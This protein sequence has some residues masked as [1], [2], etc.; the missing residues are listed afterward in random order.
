MSPRRFAAPRRFFRAAPLALAALAF[1]PA[2][3]QPGTTGQV[4]AVANPLRIR[5]DTGAAAPLGATV[6]TLRPVI[7]GTATV[8][9]LSGTYTV[10]GQA[11]ADVLVELSAGGGAAGGAAAGGPAVGHRVEVAHAARPSLIRI[12]SDPT[13]AAV[14]R[15]GYPLG[16]TPLLVEAAP[17]AHDFLVTAAGYDP[18]PMPM[19]VPEG[20][21]LSVVQAL[22]RPPPAT[23]LFVS[24]EIAFQAGRYDEAEAFLTRAAQNTDASLTA[25]QTADLPSLAFAA[26]LGAGVASRG[27][28]RGLSPAQVRDAVSKIVFVH[29]RRGQVEIA[30]GALAEIAAV[31][32]DDPAVAT[33]RALLGP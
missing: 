21:L 16:T 8:G 3:A 4:V 13:G 26:D 29:K 28:A 24:A 2:Q 12:E 19:Q 10:V 22:S 27:A 7:V 30:R 20:E 32:A 15:S 1:A 17:G 33:V 9:V 25:T 14:S 11:G 6:Y 5:L 18:A 23:H 31:L